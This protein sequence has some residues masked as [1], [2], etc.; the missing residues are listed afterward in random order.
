MLMPK[1]TSSPPTT[2]VHPLYLCVPPYKCT[3][4]RSHP[5]LSMRAHPFLPPPPYP[6]A[7]LYPNTPSC[8]Y[9]TKF[10]FSKSFQVF[11]H[12]LLPHPC[13][14]PTHACPLA[15]I[16]FPPVC[17]PHSCPPTRTCPSYPCSP[18]C[19]CHLPVCAHPY[20]APLLVYALLPVHAHSC[21]PSWIRACLLQSM[22]AFLGFVC[23]LLKYEFAIVIIMWQLCGHHCGQS[24][25]TFYP[26]E[27]QHGVDPYQRDITLIGRTC[28]R[29][30]PVGR[31][32]A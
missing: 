18:T 5:P 7:P 21:L 25:F 30:G 8:P 9:A 29:E 17:A 26:V 10:F 23:Q 6:C 16:C 31:T 12:S 27:G 2:H 3:P 14:P 22:L 20:A 4:T 28:G 32:N 11:H 19:T 13:A 24:N 1:H 15:H